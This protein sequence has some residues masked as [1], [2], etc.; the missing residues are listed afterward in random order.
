MHWWLGR[1]EVFRTMHRRGAR[2]G[3]PG[4][5][6]GRAWR[7]AGGARGAHEARHGDEGLDVAR[8]RAVQAPT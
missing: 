8:A 6:H 3:G 7:R 2:R 4:G 5:A 1:A